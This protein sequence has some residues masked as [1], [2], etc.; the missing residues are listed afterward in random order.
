MVNEKARE[1]VN[2]ADDLAND[3][4]LRIARG[5]AARKIFFNENVE[6][7]IEELERLAGQE[8]DGIASKILISYK[9]IVEDLKP[10]TN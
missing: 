1:L 3:S 7:R 9:N 5:L 8:H 4:A 2:K 6:E 10:K